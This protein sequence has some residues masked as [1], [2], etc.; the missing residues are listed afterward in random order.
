MKQ[1]TDYQIFTVGYGNRKIDD[2]LKL[3]KKYQINLLIDVRSYPFSRFQPAYRKNLLIQYLNSSD[4]QYL[5]MG[6][7]LG[8]KP[9]NKELYIGDKLDY[10]KV[11]QNSHYQFGLQ[12]LKE[13]TT[14]GIQVALM[15]S[16]L[17]E[18]HCHRKNLIAESLIATE[19]F[20]IHHIDKKGQLIQHAVFHPNLF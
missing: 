6:D 14:T 4:I 11:N 17:D 16:E 5:F 8:G 18:N 15:C 10:S 7:S 12:K 19:N 3:L 20:S 2:F 13:I 1:I 9:K